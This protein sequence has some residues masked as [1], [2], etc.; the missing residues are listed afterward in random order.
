MTHRFD[1]NTESLNT[2]WL[3]DDFDKMCED[4][5]KMQ[6]QRAF[7]DL[8]DSKS[9]EDAVLIMNP[10]HKDIIIESGLKCC[11]LWSNLC[12]EDKTYMVTDKEIKANLREMIDNG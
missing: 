6:E 11:I 2:D 12:P 5:A 3:Y 4:Y 7:E 1:E 8:K 9:I 10:K